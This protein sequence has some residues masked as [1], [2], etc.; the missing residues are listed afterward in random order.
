MGRQRQVYRIEPVRFPPDFPARLECFR[1]ASGL[2]WRELARRLQVDIRLVKRWRKGTS[3]GSGSLVILF[4]LATEMGL[5][6]H[7]LPVVKEAE[8]EGDAP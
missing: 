8:A 6:H 5:L 7:L 2:T 4:T 3:P 1:E